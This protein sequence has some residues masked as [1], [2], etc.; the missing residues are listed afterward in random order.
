[1]SEILPDSPARLTFRENLQVRI[2]LTGARLIHKV[3]PGKL[4]QWLGKAA[5]GSS[6]ASYVEAKLARDQILTVSAYCRGGDACL[7]RSIAVALVCRQRGIWPTWAVGVLAVPPFA[8]H[9]WVEAEGH[10][11]DEPMD[12]ADYKAFFKVSPQSRLTDRLTDR[13]TISR[14]EVQ[15]R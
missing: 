12:E 8:A 11:V 2:A 9:A 7:L 15:P 14:K 10:I 1:M 3:S 5:I 6:P 13:Q 4:R